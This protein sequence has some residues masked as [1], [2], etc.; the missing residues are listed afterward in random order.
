MASK[1]RDDFDYDLVRVGDC[2]IDMAYGREVEDRALAKFD[3]WS[4]KMAGA[5]VL[6]LRDDGR[7]AIL[8]GGHR[9]TKYRMM[10]GDDAQMR[11][12]IYIDLTV[13]EEA[14]LW[15]GFNR[16]RKKTQPSEEFKSDL[17]ALRPDAIEIQSILD[18]L[19]L[20]F[21]ARGASKENAIEGIETVRKL[22]RDYGTNSVREILRTLRDSMGTG[23]GAIQAMIIKG[24]ASFATRYYG[25]PTFDKARLEMILT[26]HS[27][28]QI[29]SLASTIRSASGNADMTS[30]IGMALLQLYNHGLRRQQLPPWQATVV[31][32]AKAA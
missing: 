29:K 27:A 12:L 3:T 7:F 30:C 16:D 10:H 21:A 13:A 14:D 25:L 28:A 24:L 1:Q 23:E 15:S 17:T 11:A 22:H 31:P 18:S 8:D 9:L 19:G 32:K 6:S 5:I 26:T 20:H 4:D 2:F